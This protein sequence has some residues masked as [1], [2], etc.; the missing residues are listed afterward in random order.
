[1]LAAVHALPRL[2]AQDPAVTAALRALPFVP[3]ARGGLQPPGRLYDSRCRRHAPWHLGASSA[4]CLWLRNS[5]ACA[6]SS[7]SCKIYH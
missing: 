5:P 7:C 2:A 6:S 1:M 3:T 4:N